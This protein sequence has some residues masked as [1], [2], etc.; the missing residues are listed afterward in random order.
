MDDHDAARALF[1]PFAAGEIAPPRAGDRV[2]WLNALGG[3][4]PPAMIDL[5]AVDLTVQQ[6]FRP[7][8]LPFLRAGRTVVA[9][10]PEDG[11][12]DA[13]WVC[14]RKQAEENRAL[15][16]AGL[17]RL[18]RGGMFVAAAGNDEGG[19]R[20]AAE[21][22]GLGV[23]VTGGAKYHCRYVY[24]TVDGFDEGAVRDAI[25]AGAARRMSVGAA[26]ADLWTRPGLFGGDRLDKG[27]A[28]LLQH[29]PQH[30]SGAGVDLGCGTGILARHILRENGAVT[31]ILCIDAEARAVEMAAL[32]LAHEARA[33]V[34][35]AD[36]VAESGLAGG[37][38]GLDWAVS[39]P[40]FHQGRRET[41]D[42]GAGFITAAHGMLRAGGVLWMV[43]NA[44]LP[45][46]ARLSALFRRVEKKAEGGGF[47]IYCA[48]K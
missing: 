42:V 19:R 18:R 31:D 3:V 21:M 17:L 11:A 9:E 43:A 48:E 46:E 26:G 2:L 28:F 39:N 13:V 37:G 40:P 44:H 32:N 1:V 15:L 38:A 27:S 24:A 8:A 34:L 45:Y 22:A 14:G 35:W 7:W 10:I 36:V 5:A 33:R 12:Y 23:A 25:R 20:L 16:A 30:F 47:K 41:V 29:L 6:S 4:T